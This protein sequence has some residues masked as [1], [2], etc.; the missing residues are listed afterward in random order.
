MRRKGLDSTVLN[1]RLY[2]NDKIIT[3]TLNK[4]LDVNKFSVSFQ[5][6]SE[7]SSNSASSSELIVQDSNRNLNN[8]DLLENGQNKHSTDSAV[9]VV[10]N[11]IPESMKAEIYEMGPYGELIV[12]EV[13]IAIPSPSDTANVLDRSIKAL[14]F[15]GRPFQQ[16]PAAATTSGG[17]NF[18]RSTQQ[19][20]QQQETGTERWVTGILKMEAVWAVSSDGKSL[21][22]SAKDLSAFESKFS[23]DPL[24]RSGP[25]GLLSLRKLMVS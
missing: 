6:K 13:Y 4:P 14:Q 17:K 3:T 7:M 20:L 16:R 19:S 5:G 1:V 21:G 2:Y 15:T 22:P 9:M 24:Q 11:E 23:T 10:V 8:I 12:G 18:A 25:A